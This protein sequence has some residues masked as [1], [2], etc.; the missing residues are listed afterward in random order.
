[1]TITDTIRLLLLLAEK[2]SLEAA[3][4]SWV[5]RGL[6]AIFDAGKTVCSLAWAPEE[7]EFVVLPLS[8]SRAL[9]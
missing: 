9:V 8:Y 7:I 2:V 1:M 5:M 6:W 4:K 3:V